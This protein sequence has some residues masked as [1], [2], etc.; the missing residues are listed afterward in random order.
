MIDIVIAG[1]TIRYG[2]SVVRMH[3]ANC[4]SIVATVAELY[5][6]SNRRRTR[7]EMSGPPGSPMHYR[8]L[9]SCRQLLS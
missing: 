7:A 1:L 2:G 9:Q 6:C 5:I 4:V 3:A 8:W